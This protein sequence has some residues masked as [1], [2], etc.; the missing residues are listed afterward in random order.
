MKE[1][2]KKIANN[3]PLTREEMANEILDN[4]PLEAQDIG[5]TLLKTTYKDQDE[6]LLSDFI[7]ELNSGLKSDIN[8]S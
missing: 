5:Y 8:N 6:I 1:V 4:M 7:Y 3:E 2:R